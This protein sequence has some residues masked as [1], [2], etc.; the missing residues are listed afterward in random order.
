[1]KY[2]VCKPCPTAA[3]CGLL[4]D[5]CPGQYARVAYR[6]AGFGSGPSEWCWGVKGDTG[7]GRE[8]FVNKC[9]KCLGLFLRFVWV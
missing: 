3:E 1:M 5:A 6:S 4:L 7:S 2:E 9:G 8:V